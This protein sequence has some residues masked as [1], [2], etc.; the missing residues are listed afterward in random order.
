MA[1]QQDLFDGQGRIPCPA[2]IRRL[3]DFAFGWIDARLQRDG[4][5]GV[6]ST[7]EIAA[8]AFLCLVANRSGLSWYRRER[9]AQQ[10]GLPRDEVDQALQRLLDLDLV[11]FRPFYARSRDGFYQVLSLP[12]GGPA[13][14]SLAVEQAIAQGG[15]VQSTV[16]DHGK[17]DNL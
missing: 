6:M 13:G 4:W 15:T 16:P 17:G 10:L 8:Y 3:S 2:R 7:K 11:A 1:Q 9:I 14:V 12:Q 5:F